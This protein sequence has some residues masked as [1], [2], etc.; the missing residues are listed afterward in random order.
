MQLLL[1]W[2]INKYYISWVC[3][4]SLRYAAC[5]AHAPCHLWPVRLSNIFPPYLI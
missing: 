4:C 3:V 1:Q 5:N 2:K